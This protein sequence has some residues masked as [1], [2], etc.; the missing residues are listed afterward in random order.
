MTKL[1]K[2][3]GEDMEEDI[4]NIKRALY[5]LIKIVEQ[6]DLLDADERNELF[7][8]KTIFEEE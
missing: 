3:K 5:L 4:K 8:L 7:Y 6:E 1:K 2:T